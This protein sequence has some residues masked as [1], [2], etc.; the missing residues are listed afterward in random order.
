[1]TARLFLSAVVLAAF[2]IGAADAARGGEITIE[3]VEKS[4]DVLHEG[5]AEDVDSAY[6]Y[7]FDNSDRTV[8]LMQGLMR[9]Q[10]A[11]ERTTTLAV[12]Q[13][14]ILDENGRLRRENQRQGLILKH[15]T[16][17]SLKKTHFWLA[18]VM[19]VALFVIIVDLVR[20]KLLRIEYSWLWMLTG[21]TILVLIS[22]GLIDVIA[23][24]L[25]AR[26]PQMLFFAGVFFVTLISLH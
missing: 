7:L 18:V 6:H 13:R 26:V 22:S 21:A 8:P 5:T 12:I 1:M 3:A 2:F 9:E 4:L 15:L 20:R 23:G 11:E 14:I 25:G 24:A 17:Y 16:D 10:S 19:S